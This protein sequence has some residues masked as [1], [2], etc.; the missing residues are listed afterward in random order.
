MFYKIEKKSYGFRL[1]F[2]GMLDPENAEKYTEELLAALATWTG[3]VGVM[4]DLTKAKPMPPES[5]K[6]VAAG[7]KAVLMKGLT[8][9]V[10]VVPSGLMRMQM[11]RLAKENGTYDKARYIDSSTCPQ[12]ESVALNWIVLGIDPD[13]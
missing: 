3:S 2:D 9:A 11:M 1:T 8:R 7:Y 4:I 10:S 6:I 5:Q 13:L 12:W